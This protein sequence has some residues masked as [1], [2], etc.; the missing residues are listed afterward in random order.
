MA[1]IASHQTLE[2]HKKILRMMGLTGWSKNETIGALH[3]FYYWC[4]DLAE[5]GDLR[6]FTP[7]EIVMSFDSPAD[8]A[9]RTVENMI[10]AEWIDRYP[11][12][13]VHNWWEIAGPLFCKRYARQPGKI[14]EI[15]RLCELAPKEEL[16]LQFPCSPQSSSP[17]VHRVVPQQSTQK[18]RE[19]NQLQKQQSSGTPYRIHLDHASKV[20]YQYKVLS[21]A[22]IRDKA[23]DIGNWKPSLR[24]ARDIIRMGYT[25][26]DTTLGIRAVVNA[27]KNSGLN[28]NLST[29]KRWLPIWYNDRTLAAL[30]PVDRGRQAGVKVAAA[31]GAK[32]EKF[33]S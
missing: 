12:L 22:R 24:A 27:L 1:W 21:G 9:T 17:A 16:N 10:A 2:R 15:K 32:Y 8:T 28:W 18:R 13:R 25:F 26:R 4:L 29:V 11:H 23:W 5:D 6:K 20:I 14:A 7:A 31:Q 33:G 30:M 3:R 19:E